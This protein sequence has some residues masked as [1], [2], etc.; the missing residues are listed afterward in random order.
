MPDTTQPFQ[1]TTNKPLGDL[2]TNKY[3]YANFIYPLDLGASAAGKDHYIVFH[4]NESENTQYM[5]AGTGFVGPIQSDPSVVNANTNTAHGLDQYGNSPQG[6]NGNTAKQDFTTQTL[7]PTQRVATT[8]IL[9]MPLEIQ[10]AYQIDWAQTE[11]GMAKEAV[12]IL[13]SG[14]FKDLFISGGASAVKQFGEKL[15]NFTGENLK[16][17]ASLAARMVI[18]NHQEVIFNGIQF[19]TFAFNFRFTPESEDEAVNV[20]NIIRAFKFYAAPEIKEGLA[21]RFWIYPAEFDIQYY[22]NGK[23]NDFLNKISTCALTSCAVNYTS[24]GHW[25][26]FRPSQRVQGAPSVCTDLALNFM[27]LELITK[28]RVLEGYVLIPFWWI[29]P[30]LHP[31]IFKLHELFKF[32]TNYKPM[33]LY[34]ESWSIFVI[35]S[36]IMLMGKRMWDLLPIHNNAGG[37]IDVVPLINGVMQSMKQ[38]GNMVLKILHLK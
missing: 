13:K 30:L 29:L 7:R 26:A 6:A 31:I 21:G 8:I 23:P 16:D 38:F 5:T 9:Y 36:L 18:N 35:L 34:I 12:D 17:A 11:L 20:D 28:S 32:L 10:T 1:N 27:E 3:A 19:R 33:P 14:S 24:S 2:D 15:N 25:A 4:I 22:A 37:N